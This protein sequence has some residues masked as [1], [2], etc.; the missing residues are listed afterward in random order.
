MRS[1]DK[2][3][4]LQSQ[5]ALLEDH[6]SV[7]NNCK[8]LATHCIPG[9]GN[10]V[11]CGGL[12]EHQECRLRCSGVLSEGTEG[13]ASEAQDVSGVA[14]GRVFWGVPGCTN[15]IQTKSPCKWNKN[16]IKIALLKVISPIQYLSCAY[17]EITRG[18]S[19]MQI[20]LGIL[21]SIRS[22]STGLLLSSG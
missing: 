10:P 7:P 21:H 9:P 15:T 18:L 12:S 5:A 3:Q 17:A 11:P 8:H 2:V 13:A 16:G 22:V 1:G 14:G 20:S 4:R 19:E 6:V